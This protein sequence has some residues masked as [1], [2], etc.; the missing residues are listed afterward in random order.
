MM[1]VSKDSDKAN[2]RNNF[3]ISTK[4]LRL[5]FSVIRKYDFG[6]VLEAKDLI[7]ELLL[8]LLILKRENYPQYQ[9]I[10]ISDKLYLTIVHN[11]CKDRYEY[12]KRRRSARSKSNSDKDPESLYI[13][14]EEENEDKLKTDF[15]VMLSNLPEHERKV[16]T[17]RREGYIHKEIA[18][19]LKISVSASKKRASRAL[20]K[21]REM[22]QNDYHFDSG[23]SS[24]I[25]E[26]KRA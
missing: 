24:K 2:D 13:M 14:K 21:I 6:N 5:A 8:K 4:M 19:R 17:L 25:D 23:P 12:E 9:A 1:T 22:L 18:S 3:P 11:I 20:M 26:N 7:Q 10:Y 15:D 16:F